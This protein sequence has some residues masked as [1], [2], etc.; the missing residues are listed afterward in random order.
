MAT[1]KFVEDYRKLCNSG[2]REQA[3]LHK[4]RLVDRKDNGYVDLLTFG[5]LHLGHPGCD[6]KFAE[7]IL[8]KAYDDGSYILSMGDLGEFSTRTSPGGSLFSQLSP[9]KQIDEIC[10][11]LGPFVRDGRMIGGHDGNHENR[12]F[13]AAGIRVAKIIC[14]KLGIPYLGAGGHHL[15]YAGGQ[16]YTTYALHGSSGA[17]KREDKVKRAKAALSKFK[18][19]LGLHA[20]VHDIADGFDIYEEINKTKKTVEVKKKL[21]LITGHYLKWHGTY[22]QEKNYDFVPYGS[23]KVRYYTDTH[24]LKLLKE[25]W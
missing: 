17:N 4:A 14:D 15:I 3:R 16:S 18:C 5:D 25:W 21:I 10:R 23:P 1:V 19:E 11:I 20:H 8:A 24:K 7:E 12:T 22:A 9:E 6:M 2:R 13:K